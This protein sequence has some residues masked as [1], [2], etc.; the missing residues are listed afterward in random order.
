MCEIDVRNKHISHK[1]YSGSFLVCRQTRFHPSL[2][3]GPST[4]CPGRTPAP[5]AP[6][7]GS[8]LG[9]R[10]LLNLTLVLNAS[11]SLSWFLV[12]LLLFAGCFQS[13][14][15]KFPEMPLFAPPSSQQCRLNRFYT[16]DPWL[17]EGFSRSRYTRTRRS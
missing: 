7:L 6:T 9:Q 17:Q 3:H 1:R 14:T 2:P 15:E 16:S 13:I 10:A 12:F 8:F 5:P 4:P 11:A